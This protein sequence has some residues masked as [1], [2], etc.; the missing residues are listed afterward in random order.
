M[1][2][3]NPRGDRIEQVGLEFRDFESIRIFVNMNTLEVFEMDEDEYDESELIK[4]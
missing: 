3:R 4:E 2:Y 1:S